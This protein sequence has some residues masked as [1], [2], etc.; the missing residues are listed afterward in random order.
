M[1]KE[2]AVLSIRHLRL[3][4]QHRLRPL[5]RRIHPPPNKRAHARRVHAPRVQ[6]K[7]RQVRGLRLVDRLVLLPHPRLPLLRQQ[8]PR[9]LDDERDLAPP[10]HAQVEQVRAPR[11]GHERPQQLLPHRPLH[12]P[13][14]EAVD[15]PELD[16]AGR[17]R[18]Q[19]YVDAGHLLDLLFCMC[20]CVCFCVCI[21]CMYVY[22][23][24][25]DEM[26]VDMYGVRLDEQRIV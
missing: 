14:L 18:R 25:R 5:V 11:L 13:S 7:R 4:P 6:Q 3:L 20:V 16:Q 23:Y 21:E 9:V 26:E 24:G 19:A 8:G 1:T 22:V 12:H 2:I 15:E 17:L 10:E